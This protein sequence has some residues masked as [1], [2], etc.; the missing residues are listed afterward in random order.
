M[1]TDYIMNDIS[2]SEKKGIVNATSVLNE[3]LPEVAKDFSR[4]LTHIGH[5]LAMV[6]LELPEAE[7]IKF[8]DELGALNSILYKRTHSS[9]MADIPKVRE[10]L[11]NL[12]EKLTPSGW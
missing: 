5:S 10:G 3:Q 11:N 6:L 9:N 2:R 1:Y 12:T 4:Q 7:R 8:L